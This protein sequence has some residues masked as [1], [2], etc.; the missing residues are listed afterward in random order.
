MCSTVPNGTRT[1]ASG[2]LSHES[3]DHVD[4]PAGPAEGGADDPATGRAVPAVRHRAGDR[5]RI[6][7]SVAQSA[8]TMVSGCLCL[9]VP[10]HA[11]AGP[12]LPDILWAGP[13]PVHPR[14][15]SVAVP[16]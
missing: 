15:F 10:R 7:A 4:Q 14:Q 11:A 8:D 3:G 5:R 13:D 16:A 6:D 9:R 1:A 2:G 12:D